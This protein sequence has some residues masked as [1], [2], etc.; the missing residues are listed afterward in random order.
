MARTEVRVS[1]FGGQGIILSG[2]IIGKAAAIFDKKNATMTQAYGPESRGGAC[3]AQVVIS[4]EEINDPEVSTP[5]VVVAMSQE[6]FTTFTKDLAPGCTILIDEDLVKPGAGQ[7]KLFAV[8]A[9][10]LAE[11][12][13]KKVVANII[14][15]GFFAG[16]TDVVSREAMEQAIQSSVPARFAELNLQAFRRGYE[17]AVAAA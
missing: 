7:D 4:E 16:K 17:L 13:G 1:G 14:M 5:N 9:M 3:S 6:A 11:E 10:R 12:M 15:L 8:P 2:Y